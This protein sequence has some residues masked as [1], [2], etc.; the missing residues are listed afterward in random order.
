MR[1]TLLITMSCEEQSR[2]VS[3]RIFKRSFDTRNALLQNG[4]RQP[5]DNVI[6]QSAAWSA[7]S[8]NL[9]QMHGIS[10]SKSSADRTSSTGS[11]AHSPTITE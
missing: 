9:R 11:G 3:G 6:H 4:Y 2:H 8:Q 5:H 1:C 10:V 7:S